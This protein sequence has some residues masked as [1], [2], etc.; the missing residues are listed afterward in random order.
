M[1]KKEQYLKH[2]EVID[3]WAKS[4]SLVWCRDE[5]LDWYELDKPLWDVAKNYVIND[6]FV[7]FR[8]A[9]VDGKVVEQQC[10]YVL[11]NYEPIKGDFDHNFNYR[12]KPD[13]PKFRVGDWIQHPDNYVFQAEEH[14][15]P[16]CDGTE[17][18]KLWE[19]TQGE[20]CVFK[21]NTEVYV[22]EKWVDYK[23][24]LAIWV[25]PLEFIKKFN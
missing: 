22:I 15:I 19:P 7:E 11:Y 3:W 14:F 2:K 4:D 17:E 18:H 24:P 1:L 6:Q 21:H 13:K 16:D 20:W 23:F 8:K 9:L 25:R 5:H 12:I 10:K